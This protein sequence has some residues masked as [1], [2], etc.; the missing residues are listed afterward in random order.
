MA[1]G[2]HSIHKWTAFAVRAQLSI[3]EDKH[4]EQSLSKGWFGF[5]PKI[6]DFDGFSLD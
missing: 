1:D 2:K 5:S 3:I 4:C 6:Q